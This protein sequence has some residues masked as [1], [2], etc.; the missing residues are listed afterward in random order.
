VGGV[1]GIRPLRW[2]DIAV[3]EPLEA[4]LF[5]PEAWTAASFWSELAQ[6]DARHYLVAEDAG[7][8]VGY[9]GLAVDPDDATVLTLAVDRPHWGR[10]IGATLLTAL[11]DEAHRR[12]RRTV[13]LEVRVDNERARALYRRFGFVD[14]GR[15][16]GYYAHAGVD[17]V[18]MARRG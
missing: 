5:G 13:R 9:A 4:K 1:V 11:L 16:P 8:L 2:W 15:R 14:V 10:G 12:G 18:V 6:P 17:A 7:R 3:I